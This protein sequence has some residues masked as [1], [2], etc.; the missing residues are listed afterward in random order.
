MVKPLSHD[1][2]EKRLLSDPEVRAEYDRLKPEFD[3][4]NEI[5]SAR[6]AAGMTQA[7]VARKM[8]TTQ[9]A[10]ARMESA[11]SCGRLPSMSMLKR[12]AEATGK[13]LSIR[14]I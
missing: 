9:S 12:Y 1:E 2:F 11:L 13:Q 14:L 4:L 10:I 8:S 7:E 5:L 3:L 6:K